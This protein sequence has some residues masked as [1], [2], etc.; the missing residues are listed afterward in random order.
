LNKKEKLI[1]KILIPKLSLCVIILSSF[2]FVSCGAIIDAIG[3]A[4]GF[5]FCLVLTLAGLIAWLFFLIKD[6]TEKRKRKHFAP[7][8]YA[9][10]FNF[11]SLCIF[12]LCLS[13]LFGFI[14]K[15]LLIAA[16]IIQGIILIVKRKTAFVRPWYIGPVSFIIFISLLYVFGVIDTFYLV[17]PVL[18]FSVTLTE[19]FLLALS[20]ILSVVLALLASDYKKLYA[21]VFAFFT[22]LGITIGG[23]SGGGIWQI[24]TG[25]AAG[26]IISVIINTVAGLLIK[27][28]NSAKQKRLERIEKA[29]PFEDKLAELERLAQ[30]K[31]KKNS[32]ELTKAKRAFSRFKSKNKMD[33][34]REFE[35]FVNN[36]DR[37]SVFETSFISIFNSDD[38]ITEAE[39]QVLIIQYIA[40]GFAARY[41]VSAAKAKLEND[42]YTKNRKKAL[43]FYER[44]SDIYDKLTAAQK[45]RK[46]DDAAKVLKIGNISAKIPD[47]LPNMD[48]LA[49]RLSDTSRQEF[50]EYALNYSKFRNETKLTDGN[51]AL[52]YFA[53]GLI[54]KG[55]SNYENNEIIKG[56]LYNSQEKYI[57]K[58]EKLEKGR[59]QADGFSERAGELNRALEGTM[60]AYEKMFTKIYNNLYPANDASKSKKAREKNKKMHGTYFNEEEVDE[61]IYLKITGQFLLDLVFTNFEG[62]NN[63]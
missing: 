47:Q 54:M 14:P 8:R 39:E 59:L 2:M 29:R 38:G 50:I 63:G 11:L 18:S 52:A 42:I 41:R 6:R 43:L 28:K 62:D 40:K 33:I 30:K 21:F 58:I 61:V 44:L 37:W 27:A 57:R 22:L 12:V 56:E 13:M 36:P 35:L 32:A 15:P 51:S 34:D 24:L 48:V 31:H 16:I 1:R 4:I 55:I 5:L 25:L 46:I 19:F 23:I 60:N 10:Y 45:E 9:L 3:T 7:T 49:A 26:G 17:I 20:V 53:G